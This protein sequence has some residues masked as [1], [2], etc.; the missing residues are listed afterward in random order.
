VVLCIYRGI[1]NAY[2]YIELFDMLVVPSMYDESFDLISLGAMQVGRP[3]VAFAYG[4]I[5]DVYG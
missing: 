4:G 5:P 1:N 2:E 3:V